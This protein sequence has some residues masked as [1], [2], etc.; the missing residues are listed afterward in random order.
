VAT[1]TQTGARLVYQGQ[2]QG[3]QVRLPVFLGRFPVEP[4]NRDLED[5]YRS[6]L[7]A[8]ADPTFRTGRWEL[9]DRWGWPDNDSFNNLVAWSWDGAT[10]WLIVVNLSD[11][12]ATGLVRAP[13]QDLQGRRWQLVDPTQNGSFD[14]DGD[15]LAGGLFVELE[16][17]RWHLLRLD[18]S[19]STRSGHT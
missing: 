18:S 14:R 6:L 16:G 15:D 17:W 12:T 19:P 13:W 3:R 7:T 8:V 5:F 2:L 9:C 4:V 10:R 1:L 11:D